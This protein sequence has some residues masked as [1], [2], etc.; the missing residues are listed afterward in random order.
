MLL[1]TATDRLAWTLIGAFAIATPLLI[2]G[3]F[4]A[5]RKISD[6]TMLRLSAWSA[7]G[8]LYGCG[9]WLGL[10]AREYSDYAI[11]I[12][13][14]AVAVEASGLRYG[15]LAILSYRDVYRGEEVQRAGAAWAGAIAGALGSLCF[16]AVG[17]GRSPLG[18]PTAAWIALG[19]VSLAACAELIVRSLTPITREGSDAG[20]EP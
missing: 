9:T 16:M 8:L 13:L 14:I 18:V 7:A 10:W 1:A 4:W 2:G 17:W 19:A 15:Q 20:Q 5:A 6:R 11:W 3:G 12:A